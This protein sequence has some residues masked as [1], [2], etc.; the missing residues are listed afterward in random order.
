MNTITYPLSSPVM[1]ALGWTL[2]H[3]LWQGF[4][5]VLS[6][7]LVLH[8]FRRQSSAARYR[9][10]VLALLA[11]PLLSIGTFV[12]YYKPLLTVT[13]SGTTP[14]LRS[15]A[16]QWHT[17]THTLPWH[18]QIQL[19]L[20]N[21]LS[22]F[23][24]I[25]LVGVV[26][27]GVR[28]TGGWLYLQHLNR[29][30]AQPASDRVADLANHLRSA[31]QIRPVVRIRESARIVVP[32]V[33]NSLKPVLLLP[34]GLATH[35]S[36]QELEAVLAHEL[37]HVKRH[38][39]AV[40]LLQSVLEVLYFFHPAIWWLSARI[41][42]EREHCCDD[43]AIQAC[44]NNG[45][46]LAQAL[47]RVEELRLAQPS[48]T[49]ALAMALTTK[50]QLLL[51]RVRRALGV[52]TRP[53]VSNG[54]L[55]GLTLA[56]LLLVSASVYAIQQQP[57]PSKPKPQSYRR[58]SA[59]N[60][61]EF[62]MTDNN[63]LDYMTWKGQKLP[64]KHVDQ[65]Q[66]QFDRVMSGQLLLDSIPQPDR[67]MLLA[68]IE[69]K[70]S[71]DKGMNALDQ[72]T[73]DIKHTSIVSPDKLDEELA[74]MTAP[75]KPLADTLKQL[76]KLHQTRLD[77]LSRLMAQRSNQMEALYRQMEKLRFPVEAIERSQETLE[78]RKQ[79]LL[80]ER[81]RILQKRQQMMDA[82]VE[83]KNKAAAAT[84]E[85]QLELLEPEIKKQELNVE[86][87]DKQLEEAQKRAETARQPMDQLE[88]EIEKMTKRLD[89]L[90]EEMSRH[91]EKVAHI[92]A[93]DESDMDLDLPIK[94]ES[95]PVKRPTRPSRS[96][97]ATVPPLP[98]TPAAP[99]A[100]VTP[101]QAPDAV[102]PAL[103]AAPAPASKRKK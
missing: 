30:A 20:D 96:L 86:E 75:P 68:L 69:T 5:L 27:F 35:L 76:R 64:A 38:D 82:S 12:W 61:T 7:A 62:S 8:L 50:R 36:I 95:K 43:L 2:F 44:G 83:G 4:A 85:K 99:P 102:V 91:S 31:L 87:L 40:N 63:K 57:K 55:V 101:A 3:A 11:Q 100:F 34:I 92:M 67:D 53:I 29:T 77:S 72:W 25:Y 94:V 6:T 51:H 21:H 18:T 13:S 90:S 33:V 59:G 66:Q 49:P 1:Y 47:A 23:V 58:L 97:R 65:L 45:R 52:S 41:R 54:S 78:W 37:A 42:E 89:L 88:Q 81:Q 74:K 70:Y 56:T 17:I 98:A 24:L 28:L 16:T 10:G 22:Q 14:A 15:F 71:F 19:F 39:Y 9:I 80:E 84:I 48:Q 73:A 93:E 60:G 46:I 79:R 32:M 103:P 26:L